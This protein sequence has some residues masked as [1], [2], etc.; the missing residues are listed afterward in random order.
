MK[1]KLKS[2]HE[3]QRWV[4]SEVLPNIR[5]YGAH[6]EPSNERIRAISKIIRA[7]EV[8]AI[9]SYIKYSKKRGLQTGDD[10]MVYAN[11]SNLANKYSDIETGMRDKSGNINLL[12]LITLEAKIMSTLYNSMIKQVDPEVI[13]KF[14]YTNV[15][16]TATYFYENLQIPEEGIVDFKFKDKAYNKNNDNTTIQIKVLDNEGTV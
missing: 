13:L 1:S 11:L 2:A 8:S 7:M 3:F 16:E 12:I 10:K 6:I 9:S 14:V 5:K 4:T 15:Q